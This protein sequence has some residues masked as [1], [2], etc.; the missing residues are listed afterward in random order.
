MKP[1]NLKNKLFKVNDLIS[2]ERKSQ[3]HLRQ[4]NLLNLTPSFEKSISKH[5]SHKSNSMSLTW[6]RQESLL[7]KKIRSLKERQISSEFYRLTTQQNFLM[8]I[9]E[10]ISEHN[11]MPY[12]QDFLLNQLI[13]MPCIKSHYSRLNR[14]VH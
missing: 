14:H 9:S 4:T 2:L 7:I 12:K 10:F 5:S 8:I 11:K 6:Q 13:M 1:L 3:K